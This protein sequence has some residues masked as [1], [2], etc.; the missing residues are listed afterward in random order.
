MTQ[1]LF[2]RGARVIVTKAN[3][4]EFFEDVVASKDGG[5]LNFSLSNQITV[6][7]LR[8]AFSIERTLTKDPNTASISIYNLSEDTRSAMQTRPLRVRLDVGYDGNLAR[9]FD[10]DVRWA[11]NRR[12]GAEWV[13]SFQLGDGD[14]SYRFSRVAISLGPGT[15]MLQALRKVADAMGLDVPTAAAE[16]SQLAK[17]YT[18]G[19][20]LS[21][22]GH[23]ELSRITDRA[24]L[25]WS[26][27]DGRLQLLDKDGYRSEPAMTIS[28]DTGMVGMPALGPPPDKST[29]P[30]LTVSKV[31]DPTRPIV[32][33][34]II[35]V[36]SKAL[37]H[38][39]GTYRVNRCTHRGDTHEGDW[40]TEIEAV[41][42]KAKIVA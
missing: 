36:E 35:V 39:N 38:V 22:A 23:R 13:T 27:Q 20:V 4:D 42:R 10:G 2:K 32:P 8:V 30:V 3:P 16:F 19:V 14:R 25:G 6:E 18:S 31:I 11:E 37:K 41:P 17:Q 9:I 1:R 40:V 5:T 15:T 28:E 12:D 7:N 26:V 24:G 29:Q 33:G 21:G 34:S